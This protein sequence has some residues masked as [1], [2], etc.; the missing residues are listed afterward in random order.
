MKNRLLSSLVA[1]GF[2]VL[3]YG[4][5]PALAQAYLGTAQPF[6]VLGGTTVTC[7][8]AG[9]AITGSIGVSPGAAPT[10][11]PVPCAGV[12]IIPPASDPAQLALTTAYNTLAALPCASTVG[13]NLAG[14]TLTQGVYCVNAA[15]SNL[16]G[17]LTLNGQGNPNAVWVFRMSS[18]LITS[19][20]ST[21]ALINGANACAVEW[22]VSSSATIGSGTTFVGNILALTSIAMGTGA[23][24]TGRT[25]ARNGA[26]TLD[27][28][29]IGFGACGAGGGVGGVPPPFPAGVP[30][31]PQI[32]AWALLVVLL[33]SGA[34]LL[35]RRTPTE[36]SR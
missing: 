7:L 4:P 16:T 8:G 5:S 22:Q 32:G 34:Y 19:S 9:T 20:G 10:G 12:P 15:A 18:T 35:R 14:L 31:L 11:F 30:T 2:G 28:N 13:P 23:N 3:L 17:T 1:V 24:L 21:V 6:A 27:T 25:L 26:V 29:T 36:A 33:G